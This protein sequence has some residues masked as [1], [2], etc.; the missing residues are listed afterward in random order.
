MAGPFHN[1][2]GSDPAAKAQTWQTL[3]TLQLRYELGPM[4]L[5]PFATAGVGLYSMRVQPEPQPS[6]E[7]PVALRAPL[8]VVGVG[9][10]VRIL[11]W[12]A[13]T[14]D[15]EEM[16]T[17]P[18]QDVSAG[19]RVIGRA[20]GPSISSR[21]GSCCRGPDADPRPLSRESCVHVPQGVLACVRLA[22]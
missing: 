4:R 13:A 11:P 22:R 18:T 20:G 6:S 10:L 14:V 19:N 16:V 12:L 15:V 3:A 2:V 5:R 8:V 9:I 21:R 17:F 1:W 7:A